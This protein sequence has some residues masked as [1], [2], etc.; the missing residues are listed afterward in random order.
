LK[1]SFI[2]LFASD[3]E[4]FPLYLEGGEIMRKFINRQ[5]KGFTLIELLVVIAI[6]GILASV[7]LVSLSS[8]RAKSRDA[9][10]IADMRQI[11]TAVELYFNDCGG[12]PKTLTTAE[13]KT[14]SGLTCP[15]GT[16]L[17][18]FLGSIPA[19]PTPGGATYT[20]T[21]TSDSV[22]QVTFS[23]EGPVNSLASGAHT[24]NQS[25]IQ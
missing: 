1:D 15:A 3:K 20:Y 8:A 13:N 24:A 9:R 5:H 6:I 2:F 18:S 19:N 10:R 22:F 7:V 23:L 17:G 25:G 14:F 4:C 21:S 16:T 11:Q 12:Y